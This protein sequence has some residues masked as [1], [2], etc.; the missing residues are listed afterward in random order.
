[1]RKSVI[2]LTTGLALII[3]A[4]SIFYYSNNK[5]SSNIVSQDKL[6]IRDTKKINNSFV[7]N[8]NN[9]KLTNIEKVMVKPDFEVIYETQEELE[10]PSQA[11]I[12]GTVIESNSFNYN[13]FT[14]T[15]SKVKVNSGDM[16]QGDIITV[17]ENGGVTTKGELQLEDPEKIVISP[18]E[19]DDPIEVS[20]DGAP[21]MKSGDK[22]LLYL[23]LS[24]DN[25]KL[26]GEPFYV[27]I[28]SYQG[29]LTM[30]Q[31]G[32]YERYVPDEIEGS[33]YTSLKMSATEASTI[34]SN[35]LSKKSKN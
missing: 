8:S 33:G 7:A 9:S 15:S 13:G 29:K 20:F 19:W 14:Y 1:M 31:Y 28:G 6:N 24:V 25:E 2:C 12:R 11:V 17:V 32:F 23:S 3:S 5:K 22:V 16:N 34:I 18:E 10:M 4:S 30:N 26:D 27:T 35:R 21:V